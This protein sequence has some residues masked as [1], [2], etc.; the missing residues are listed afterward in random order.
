MNSFSVNT[1]NKLGKLMTSGEAREMGRGTKAMRDATPAH[2][3][4]LRLD[5]EAYF[6]RGFGVG[7]PILISCSFCA[8]VASF[9]KPS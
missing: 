4:G 8:R 3:P 7:V 1:L 5:P 2:P 9:L 6:F